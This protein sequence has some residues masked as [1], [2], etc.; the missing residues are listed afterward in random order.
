MA[1]SKIEETK[2]AQTP[3]RAGGDNASGSALTVLLFGTWEDVRPG[4]VFARALDKYA[5]FQVRLVTHGAHQAR[6]AALGQKI[7]ASL[8]G[9]PDAIVSSPK[10]ATALLEQAGQRGRETAVEELLRRT[11]Q[12]GWLQDNL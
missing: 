7:H 4:V 9:D 6:V 3:I 10:F 1:S 5:K 8:H 12:Y 11:T 2:E